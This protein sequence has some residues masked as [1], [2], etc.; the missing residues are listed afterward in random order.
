MNYVIKLHFLHCSLRF[1][2]FDENIHTILI[3][4]EKLARCSANLQ[5]ILGNFAIFSLKKIT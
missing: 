4:S 2:L 1:S 5:A 3:F